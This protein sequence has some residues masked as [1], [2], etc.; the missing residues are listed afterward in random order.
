MIKTIQTKTEQYI[1]FTD[2]EIEELGWEKGQKF[3]ISEENGAVIL[4][5]W[6]SIE[7]D[8]GEFRREALEWLINESCERDVSVGEVIRDVLVKAAESDWGL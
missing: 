5:P 4:Q 8:L 7:I 6:K 3:T 2:E 1:Q